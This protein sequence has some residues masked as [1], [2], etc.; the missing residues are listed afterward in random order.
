MSCYKTY[1]ITHLFIMV[2]GYMKSLCRIHVLQVDRAMLPETCRTDAHAFLVYMV[3][4]RVTCAHNRR[5]H[6][7]VIFFSTKLN[8]QA[9]PKKHT[10]T[11]LKVLE[12]K[13]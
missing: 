13:K 4:M 10:Q 9:L 2:Q 5:L 7:I 3:D 11:E 1:I 12:G 8:T 6:L